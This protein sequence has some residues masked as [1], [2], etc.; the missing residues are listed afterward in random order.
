MIA[1]AVVLHRERLEEDIAR[2][3]TR[4]GTLELTTE[5]KHVGGEENIHYMF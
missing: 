4:Q 3:Q 2:A 5:C 1:K